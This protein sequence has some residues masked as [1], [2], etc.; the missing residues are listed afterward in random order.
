MS[1]HQGF[2]TFDKRE[3]VETIGTCGN[4]RHHMEM[5]GNTLKIGKICITWL[6]TLISDHFLTKTRQM[7]LKIENFPMHSRLPN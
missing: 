1:I 2:E 7:L 4:N 6:E 3:P 5:M